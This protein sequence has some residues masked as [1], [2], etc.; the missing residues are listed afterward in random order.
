[1]ESARTGANSHQVG[2]THYKTA[3]EH[4]DLV[5]DVG[6][7]YLE[8]QATKYIARW[9][10]KDGFKDLQKA[11]HYINKLMEQ[12]EKLLWRIQCLRT[13]LSHPIPAFA[14]ANSYVLD[15]IH[16][17]NLSQLEGAIFLKLATWESR[18]DLEEAQLLL[19]NLMDEADPTQLTPRTDSNKHAERN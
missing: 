3:Y 15:F 16:L 13:S 19:M 8:G 4:W 7:G 12:S 2:G 17:N 6:M 18:R 9:R 11:L 5:T 10:K 14:Q 1:M